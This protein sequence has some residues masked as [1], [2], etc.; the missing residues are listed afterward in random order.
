MILIPITHGY[1]VTNGSSMV[2]TFDVRHYENRN[3]CRAS[4]IAFAH[5]MELYYP[6]LTIVFKRNVKGTIHERQSWGEN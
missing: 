6:R 2:R 3:V 4:A 1:V 5:E